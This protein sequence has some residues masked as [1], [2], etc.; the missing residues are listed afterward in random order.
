MELLDWTYGRK[1][2]IKAW[3]SSYP[4]STV[5]LR[6]LSGYYFIYMIDWSDEDRPVPRYDLEEMEQ[7]MNDELGTLQEYEARLAFRRLDT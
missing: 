7:I 2:Q 3:F 1:Q 6:A 5:I 4:H